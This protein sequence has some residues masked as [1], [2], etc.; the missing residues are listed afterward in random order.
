[1][2]VSICRTNRGYRFQLSHI[3]SG[4]SKAI[5]PLLFEPDQW[6]RWGPLLTD[7][8]SPAEQ[9]QPGMEGQV[10][11]LGFLWVSFRVVEVTRTYWRW[12]VAGMSPPADG[13]FI[14]TIGDRRTEIGFQLPLWAPFYLPFCYWALKNIQS[15]LQQQD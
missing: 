14:R 6:P 9:L 13:H 2:K 8:K 15:L 11:L 10:Q 7:V 4:P 3:V 1:M 12:T 5:R